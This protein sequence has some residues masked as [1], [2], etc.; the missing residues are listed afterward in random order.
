MEMDDIL[1]RLVEA[2]KS[3]Q[4]FT[5][6]KQAKV[7]ISNNPVLKKELEEFSLNQNQFSQK[8]DEAREAQLRYKYESLSKIPEVR[9]Y[10]NALN[11]LNQLMGKIYTNLIVSL[12]KNL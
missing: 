11:S 6:L 3:S 8:K 5:R 10:L 2:I 1:F 12:E 9:N 4:E 7:V